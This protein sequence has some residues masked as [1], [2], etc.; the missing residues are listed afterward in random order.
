M[1]LKSVRNTLALGAM[2]LA[3]LPMSACSSRSQI[4][5]GNCNSGDVSSNLKLSSCNLT[6]LN[7]REEAG[8]LFFLLFIPESHPATQMHKAELH[9]VK[10]GDSMG[11][12]IPAVVVSYQYAISSSDID[13]LLHWLPGIRLPKDPTLVL[14]RNKDELARR[15]LGREPLS[16]S[17]KILLDRNPYQEGRK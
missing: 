7:A 16:E 11:L 5:E 14:F 8:T 10:L 17:A 6:E 3:V 4:G 15:W 2:A 1:Y 12:G 13:H 9:Q